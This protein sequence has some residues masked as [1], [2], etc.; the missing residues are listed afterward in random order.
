MASPPPYDDASPTMAGLAQAATSNPPSYLQVAQSRP[1]ERLTAS[2]LPC[3]VL[4]DC[5]IYAESQP[6]RPLYELSQPP[7]MCRPQTAAYAVQRFNYQ[8]SSHDGEGNIRNRK[9]HIYDFS[10]SISPDLGEGV[11]I[12]GKAARKALV[13]K[14]A[15]IAPGPMGKWS[16]CKVTSDSHMSSKGDLEHFRAGR[17]VKQRWRRS[18]QLDWTDTSGRTV[19]T[20]TKLTRREDM[21]VDRPPRLEIRVVLESRDLD[22]LVTA[23]AARIWREAKKDLAEPM[24]WGK[25]K[26]I[27]N[28]SAGPSSS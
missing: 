19:A 7:A 10:L 8:L 13:A 12:E 1:H 4:G 5:L 14:D 15:H 6:Q 17:S 27:A 26:R 16:S 24:S 23:W 25:F 11:Y 21:S 2:E 28:T 22:L 20:E 3:L 9:R 18:D